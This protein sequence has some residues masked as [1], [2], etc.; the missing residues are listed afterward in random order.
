MKLLLKIKSSPIANFFRLSVAGYLRNSYQEGVQVIMHFCIRSWRCNTITFCD[1]NALIWSQETWDLEMAISRS[2]SSRPDRAECPFF[3][4]FPKLSRR[5][6]Y[7]KWRY[8]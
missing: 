1:P 5:F 2:S 4:L 3:V 8:Y 7:R 6:I